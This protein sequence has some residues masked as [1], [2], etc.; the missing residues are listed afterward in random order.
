[1]PRAVGERRNS[2]RGKKIFSRS[3]VNSVS[4]LFHKKVIPFY[5]M[6]PTRLKLKPKKLKSR[7][8]LKLGKFLIQKTVYVPCSN[9][10]RWFRGF[11]HARWW[12]SRVNK[13]AT[14]KGSKSHSGPVSI[15]YY[16]IERTI[17]KGNFAVVKLASHMIT[18][19]KVSPI[20]AVVIT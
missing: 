20:G 2:P 15:G 16:E 12:R 4:Y 5:Q 8:K 19:T 11:G 13:M 17:G 9:C 6:A 14:T 1:M 18:K 7:S 3:V 10:A